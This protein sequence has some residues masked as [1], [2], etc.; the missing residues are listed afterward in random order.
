M[1]AALYTGLER[2]TYKFNFSIEIKYPSQLI[3]EQR[4]NIF[5]SSLPIVPYKGLMKPKP[6]HATVPFRKNIQSVNTRKYRKY[7]CD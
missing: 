6:S 1:N 7:T 4:E 2:T 3:I 5:R